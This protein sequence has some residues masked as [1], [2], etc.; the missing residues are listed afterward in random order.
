MKRT[1]LLTQEE[2]AEI[3]TDLLGYEIPVSRV[4]H[5]RRTG[6][7][8]CI[9]TSPSG[10]RGWMTTREHVAAYVAG[11]LASATAAPAPPS[12]RRPSGQPLPGRA[13]RRKTA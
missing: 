2:A 13:T 4:W 10:T 7:L 3:L 5:L 6:K 11:L 9:P 1:R 8:Q 12:Q